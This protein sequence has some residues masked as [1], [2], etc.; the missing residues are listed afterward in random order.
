MMI[1]EYLKNLYYCKL[2]N[3]EEIDKFLNTYETLNLYQEVIKNL[4]RYI[5][6][7]EIVTVIKNFLT[8]KSPGPDE[9]TT[10]LHQTFKEELTPVFLKL[11]H[12]VQ[13]EGILPNTFY[14]YQSNIKKRKL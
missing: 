11:L 4:N 13:K 7:N 14:E 3:E 9:F 8:K 5:T 1:W 2:E 6:S 10:E 12:K